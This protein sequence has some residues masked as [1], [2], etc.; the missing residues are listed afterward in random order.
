MCQLEKT[1]GW[2]HR[3]YPQ[4]IQEPAQMSLWLQWREMLWRHDDPGR[5]Q[6]A[7]EFYHQHK[8]EMDAG[9]QVLWPE[10]FPLLEVMWDRYTKGEREFQS[11]QQGIP[12]PPGNAEFGLH[13]FDWEG[14]WFDEFPTGN[15][16]EI[17]CVDPSM[18]KDG[19]AGD[20]QAIGRIVIDRYWQ[21]WVE[22]WLEKV[23]AQQMCQFIVD[24]YRNRPAEA[25]VLES[26][27]FQ[28]LLELPFKQASESQ[29]VNLPLYLQPNY[30]VAKPVRIRRLASPLEQHTIRFKRN[31]PGTALLVDQLKKFRNPAAKGQHD[32]GPDALESGIRAAMK[33]LGVRHKKEKT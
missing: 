5:D 2:K 3:R 10:R 31:S 11:E 19:K 30:G 12:M 7:R 33:M 20:Y 16:I 8:D 26:N 25:V 15:L 14:F 27:G 22:A 13:L 1:P 6:K 17:Y 21:I 24:L 18:G 29:G 32:D 4:L 23:N 28:E 9:H